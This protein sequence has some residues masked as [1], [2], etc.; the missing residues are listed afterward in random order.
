MHRKENKNEKW[1]K[2]FWNRRRNLLKSGLSTW[3]A[4]SFHV[5][6]FE[7]ARDDHEAKISNS[8]QGLSYVFIDGEVWLIRAAASLAVQN[9]PNVIL[10]KNESPDADNS[11]KIITK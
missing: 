1:L 4:F 6:S 2:S 11:Q 7:R 10:Y 3:V 9:K 5:F 8:F